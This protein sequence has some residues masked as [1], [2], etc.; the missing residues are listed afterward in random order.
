MRQRQ[1]AI[2]ALL[3]PKPIAARRPGTLARH[4]DA[5]IANLVAMF[6][7]K[8]LPGNTIPGPVTAAR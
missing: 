2:T 6:G 4:G 3:K 5:A 1:Q 7:Q 8:Q